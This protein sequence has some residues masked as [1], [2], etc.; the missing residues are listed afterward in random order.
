MNKDYMEFARVKTLTSHTKICRIGMSKGC[1]ERAILHSNPTHT[2]P[3]RTRNSS[4]TQS[5]V[6]YCHV[7]RSTR[8]KF[9]ANSLQIFRDWNVQRFACTF[10]HRKGETNNPPCTY[11]FYCALGFLHVRL[12]YWAAS[13]PLVEASEYCPATSIG[14]YIKYIMP[15]R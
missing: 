11:L 15:L 12:H 6:A 3:A 10:P 5:I 2:Q 4:S 14:R 1:K 7:H 8:V 9:P 13:I